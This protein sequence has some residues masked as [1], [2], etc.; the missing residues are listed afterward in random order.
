[1]L[2]SYRTLID[3]VITQDE[4]GWKLILSSESDPSGNWTFA[5]V[6]S[7][8]WAEWKKQE[9]FSYSDMAHYIAEH[10][11]TIRDEVFT[12]YYVQFVT[13]L[14]VRGVIPALL[15]C[16]IDCGVDTAKSLYKNSTSDPGD[17]L[18]VWTSHYIDLVV[19]NAKAW[20][21]HALNPKQILAPTVFRAPNLQGWFNRVEKY[22]APATASASVPVA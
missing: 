10:L 2:D 20:H 4:G 5:G 19:R 22:R 6:T 17:F 13:P 8:S 9:K 1:M 12:F 3:R 15:S 16:A 14:G 21:D 7:T 18:K 11:D